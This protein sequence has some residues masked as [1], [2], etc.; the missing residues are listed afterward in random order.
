MGDQKSKNKHPS[1]RKDIEKKLAEQL[2]GRVD[3][4]PEEIERG[5]GRF[6]QRS[7]ESL[8]GTEIKPPYRRPT[9]YDT[10]FNLIHERTISNVSLEFI[11]HNIISAKSEAY[12]FKNGLR[13]LDFIDQRGNSTATLEKLRVTGEDFTRNLA[14]VIQK[15]YADL[16]STIVVERAKPDSVINYMIERYGYSRPLAEEATVLF[17]YF[18]TKANI[19]MSEELKAFRVKTEQRQKKSERVVRKIAKPESRLEPEYDESFATLKFD[20]FSFA[21]KKD[22]AAIKFAKSQINALLDYLTMKLS[23]EEKDK[24]R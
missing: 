1:S 7:R 15:A 5:V 21:V 2:S 24:T 13:F 4:S 18:C 17:V 12:K 20:E 11:K 9:W 19:S 22:L 6:I 14:E 8:G 10:F 23:E 16:F 3:L